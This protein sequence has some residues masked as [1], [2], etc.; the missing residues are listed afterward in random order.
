M[1]TFLRLSSRIYFIKLPEE[2]LDHKSSPQAQVDI[3]QY[4]TKTQVQLLFPVCYSVRQIM[5]QMFT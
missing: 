1:Y 4:D 2:I 5:G 3:D